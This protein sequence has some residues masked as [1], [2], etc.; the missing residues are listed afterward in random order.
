[1]QFKR[2]GEYAMFTV[3]CRRVIIHT[4]VFVLGYEIEW[5]VS[6]GDMLWILY[7]ALSLISYAGQPQSMFI[8]LNTL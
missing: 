1:M 5:F 8:P 2:G 7:V 6:D 4:H 3:N